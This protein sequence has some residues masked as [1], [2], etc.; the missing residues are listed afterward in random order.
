[1]GILIGGL[2][3]LFIYPLDWELYGEIQFSLSTA[4]LLSTFFSLGSHS[5]VVKYFPYFKTT[6][7]KGFLYL[8]FIYSAIN[9]VLISVLL[10]IFKIPFSSMMELGGFNVG[11][12]DENLFI[13][14]P[15][16]VLM[17][18]IA[19]LRAHSFN[20]GR[21]VFPDFISN[22]SL[23]ILIPI[24]ILLSYFSLINYTTTG[25][26]LVIYFLLIVIALIFYLKS[27]GG[28]D[29]KAGILKRIKKRK[30]VEMI[31]YM[32]YGA[33]N[34]V[35]NVLV[36]K[37]DIVMIGLLLSTT[38]V[39]YYS[40][41]LF[42][43]VVI[44]IPTKAV[45]QITSPMISKA[46]EGSKMEEIRTLYKSSSINL[47]IIGI[48]LFTLIW[49][50][51][52][53]FFKIMTNG[54]DL[55][56]YKMVFLV[57]ALTKLIDMVTSVNFFII[58]YSKYFRVNTLFI[59]ILAVSN[60]LLNYFLIGRFDVLGA[61]LSTGISM[62]LFNLLKTLFVAVKYK[63]HPFR[64]EL[65]IMTLFLATAI[66]GPLYLPSLFDSIFISIIFSGGFVI[67]FIFVCYRLKVSVEVN[68]FID[69][70]KT[71]IFN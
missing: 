4:I 16:S 19:I 33:M 1:M 7:T 41:F 61:A 49:F 68:R 52:E 64:W 43:S 10:Y 59:L 20:F 39:G 32:L 15:L 12:I 58:S 47:F 24:L 23:K 14:L 48:V 35:G 9:I 6:Q 50:N 5:L 38:K 28:L 17:V 56:I 18:Y 27:L 30:H 67:L 3:T 26:I 37:I 71:K 55:V 51:L 22:F 36:Y 60:I 40:I 54:E 21:I 8:V 53:T 66:A 25:W 34:H 62:L 63:M 46:F 42:L 13:I 57:L 65:L 44:E 2:S 45:F 31:R 69:K 70:Y 29:F 11:K